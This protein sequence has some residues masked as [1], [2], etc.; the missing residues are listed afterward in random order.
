MTRYW[1]RRVKYPYWDWEDYRAGLYG[2]TWSGEQEDARQLLANP[3]EL[4]RAMR[5]V[6]AEWPN[7]TAHHLTDDELNARAWL[8]WAACGL[9]SKVPAHLTRAAWW[10]LSESERFQAN[11]AADRVIS[12]YHGSLF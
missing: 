8:G 1:V 6:V 7:A 12:S 9:T 2:M 3:L 10:K 4:E 5:A 11:L